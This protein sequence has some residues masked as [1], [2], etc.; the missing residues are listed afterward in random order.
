M[1]TALFHPQDVWSFS[2]AHFCSSPSSGLGSI[3]HFCTS[4]D[5][6]QDD[7][8]VLPVSADAFEKVYLAI[9]KNLRFALG[10]AD[11]YAMR[12]N[13]S[14]LRTTTAAK[15]DQAFDTYVLNESN[16]VVG[17]LGKKI[18]TADWKTLGVLVR[19]K[20]GSCSRG[21]PRL[22]IHRDAASADAGQVP[23]RGRAGPLHH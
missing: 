1:V 10:L 14:H 19:E 17:Q 13:P 15:R 8:S 11:K 3:S 9:G 20:A 18:G 22:R 5:P 16:Q 2:G 23:P 21:I 6:R 4:G 7:S 12:A